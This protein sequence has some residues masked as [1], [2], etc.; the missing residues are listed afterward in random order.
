M[1][2]KNEEISLWILD[3][4]RRRDKE[5]AL[6]TKAQKSHLL[7]VGEKNYCSGCKKPF[8]EPRLVQYYAC[9][10]CLHRLDEDAKKG[11]Q[12]YFGFLHQKDKDVPVPKECAECRKVLECML[13]KDVSP[14]A[15]AEIKKWY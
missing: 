4:T 14:N 15:V 12:F 1:K 11:C 13:N 2:Q 9:P 5:N 10:H 8:S 3:E 6:K 7:D